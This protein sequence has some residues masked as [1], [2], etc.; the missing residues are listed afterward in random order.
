MLEK[1]PASW[2]RLRIWLRDHTNGE[3]ILS[4]RL[5][6]RHVSVSMAPERKTVK[7][8]TLWGG[9]GKRGCCASRTTAPNA[10]NEF[11]YAANISQFKLNSYK[12]V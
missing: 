11:Q 6:F 8:T 12:A 7:T 1:T 3:V 4:T 10:V 9:G 2:V 5:R